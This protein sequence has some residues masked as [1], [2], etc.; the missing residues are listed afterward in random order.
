MNSA[1]PLKYP[2]VEEIDVGD[3]GQCIERTGRRLAVIA[4]RQQHE[5]GDQAEGNDGQE[6]W[7]DPPDAALIEPRDRERP[8][9]HRIEKDSRDQVARD[10][11][12]DVDPDEAAGHDRAAKMK[13]HDQDDGDRAQ[14]I[15]LGPIRRH[16]LALRGLAGRTTGSGQVQVGVQP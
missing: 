2:V 14:P 13:Q 6:R 8:C 11:E 16:V 1:P 7:N 15:D 4:R 3:A 9:L 12:K 5:A 10:H